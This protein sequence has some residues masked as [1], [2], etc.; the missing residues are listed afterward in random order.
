LTQKRW[1]KREFHVQ[2]C[3]RFKLKCFYLLDSAIVKGIQSKKIVACLKHFAC[4]N[5]EDNRNLYESMVDER[6]LREIYLP[7]FKAGVDAGA[8]AVMTA[9]NGVN[10]ELSSDNHHLLQDILKDEWGFP[11]FVLTDWCNTR[12]TEKAALAGLD[13]AMP[14]DKSSLFGEPLLNAV[15]KGSISI[16]L[17]DEKVRRIFSV[18]DFVGL[19]DKISPTTGGEIN[20]KEHQTIARRVAEESMVLLKNENNN[21]WL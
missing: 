15:K 17:I 20:T 12:S 13:V 5:R 7:A 4:N 21:E 3:E 8:M 14:Y 18:Y 16:D 11:G 6:T 19:L 9:A 10:G 2:C 1:M